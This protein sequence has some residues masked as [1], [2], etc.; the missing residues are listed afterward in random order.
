V[1]IGYGTVDGDQLTG[2]ASVVKSEEMEDRQPQ[3]LMEMLIRIPGVRVMEKGDLYG[4]VSV[5]IRGSNTS[6]QGG[7]EPLFVLDGMPISFTDGELRSIN[8]NVI[9]SITVLKDA[10]ATAIYGSRGANGVIIIKTKG[11]LK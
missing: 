8:P 4:G 9:E 11:G 3:T 10:G 5:R 6:F 7:E 2:S 1:G